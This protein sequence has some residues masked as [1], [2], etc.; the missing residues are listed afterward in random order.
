LDNM[1]VVSK[2]EP[3]AYVKRLSILPLAN[4]EAPTPNLPSLPN[5]VGMNP[6]SY[7]DQG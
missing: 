3:E 6:E 1:V 7:I 2:D 4:D 5:A